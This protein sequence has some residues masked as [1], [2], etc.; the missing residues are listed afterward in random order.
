MVQIKGLIVSGGGMRIISLMNAYIKLRNTASN[1]DIKHMLGLSAGSIICLFILCGYC[2][3]ELLELVTS[4]DQEHLIDIN[5]KKYIESGFITEGRN[6]QLFI[7]SIISNK[8]LDI[9][10]TFEQMY[11]LTGVEFYVSVTNLSK[12]CME[13]FSRHTKPNMIVANAVYIS[14]AHPIYF[15]NRDVDGYTYAD[16]AIND[17]MTQNGTFLYLHPDQIITLYFTSAP[18]KVKPEIKSPIDVITRLYYIMH[19]DKISKHLDLKNTI[20]IKE[21]MAGGGMNFEL[22]YE[23]KQQYCKDGINAFEKYWQNRC[24]RTII[25]FFQKYVLK[26]L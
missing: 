23:T 13:R 25:Y 12:C 8:D 15:P 26:C 5:L 21:G 19:T 17:Y 6:L 20:I 24:A 4:V 16:G 2:D 10:I 11:Q 1:I 14:C 22:S 7:N 18:P 3:E 9:R